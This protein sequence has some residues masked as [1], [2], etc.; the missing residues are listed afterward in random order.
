MSR[1]FLAFV[2]FFRILSGKKLPPAA[3]ALLP[4]G[5]TA[6]ARP[7]ASTKPVEKAAA[8]PAGDSK[9]KGSQG[10]GLRGDAEKAR[11]EPERARA[12]PERA[13]A[14][15]ERARAEPERTRA[16]PERPKAS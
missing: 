5:A 7:E 11:A 2:C 13:R 4:D 8:R 15:P 12:E 16:E 9:D 3:M 10:A 6:G 1:L 14:E